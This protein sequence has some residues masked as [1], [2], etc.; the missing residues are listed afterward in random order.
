M[1]SVANL[2]PDYYT[3]A[4]TWIESTDD[5]DCCSEVQFEVALGM[6]ILD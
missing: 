1:I 2:S 4:A 6:E 5:V 3:N